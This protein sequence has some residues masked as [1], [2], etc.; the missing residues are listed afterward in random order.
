MHKSCRI[1]NGEHEQAYSKNRQCK[2]K[3][4]HYS[5]CCVSTN[6]LFNGSIINYTIQKQCISSRTLK[7][8]NFHYSYFFKR[9]CK[10][11]RIYEDMLQMLQQIKIIPVFINFIIEIE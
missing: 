2:V 3:C 7:H 10:L 11:I 4:R 1:S 5:V 6:G 9:N 8:V